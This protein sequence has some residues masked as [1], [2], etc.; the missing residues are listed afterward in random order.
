MKQESPLRKGDKHFEAIQAYIN[1]PTPEQLDAQRRSSDQCSCD[2]ASQCWE[3]CG[4]LGH[5]EE[6]TKQYK[7][8]KDSTPQPIKDAAKGLITGLGIVAAVFAMV[9]LF[10]DSDPLWYAIFAVLC[11]FGWLWL[12]AAD[13]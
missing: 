1:K 3:P 12:D 5:S 4:E 8:P 9:L 6:H 2:D 10:L 7:P 13:E 11:L